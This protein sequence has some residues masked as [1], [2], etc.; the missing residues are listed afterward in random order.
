MTSPDV[1][2]R[3]DADLAELRS[4]AHDLF[5]GR[6]QAAREP[7]PTHLDRPLWDTLVEVGLVPL[8]ETEERGGSAAGWREVAVV[9]RAAGGAAAAVPIVE[10]DLLARWL[11]RT[12]GM[13]TSSDIRTA[14][15]F[16]AA[17]CG[18]YV[19]WANEVDRITVLWNRSDGSRPEWAVIDAPRSHFAATAGVNLA[20][21]PRDTLQ[22]DVT[23]HAGTPVDPSVAEEFRLRGA[24]ARSL[25]I[26]GAAERVLQLCIEHTLIR[27]QFGRPLSK[28]QLVQ[29]MAAD[30]AAESAVI[31]AAADAAVALVERNGFGSPESVFAVAV[32]KSTAGHGASHIARNAH[33]IFG[34]IGF[35]Y[36]HELHRHTNRIVSWRSEFGSVRH[37]DDVITRTVI[38]A[39][40]GGLWSLIAG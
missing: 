10:D 3:A 31:R 19:P 9:L 38:D 35:T 24:L 21:E 7:A 32:A 26:A 5:A 27:E 16:D 33:Q 37:W 6:L 22:M 39:G 34:A 2:L 18:R 17:G 15:R 40:S 8:T 1:Q 20:G 28:F 4:M 12:A 14:A 11:L 36:E 25:M 29:S 30:V 23:A 13:A